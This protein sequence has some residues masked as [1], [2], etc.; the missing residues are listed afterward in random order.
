MF[1][2]ETIN[3][4]LTSYEQSYEQSPL[5]TLCSKVVVSG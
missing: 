5:K 1:V 3:E 4:S 2:T